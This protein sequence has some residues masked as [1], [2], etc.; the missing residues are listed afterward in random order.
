[1]MI[2]EEGYVQ[3]QTSRGNRYEHNRVYRDWWLVRY[4]SKT[5]GKITIGNVVILPKELMGKRIRLKIEV[6]E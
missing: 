4:H 1:M 2:S 5:S 6:I 3:R